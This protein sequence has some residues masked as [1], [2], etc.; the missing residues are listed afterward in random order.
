MV[1]LLFSGEMCY[2]FY[3]E[4]DERVLNGRFIHSRYGIL[5]GGQ[6]WGGC[7]G[8]IT[9]LLLLLGSTPLLMCTP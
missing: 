9:A 7:A 3:F 6:Y 2:F 1:R 8:C 4:G 5:A